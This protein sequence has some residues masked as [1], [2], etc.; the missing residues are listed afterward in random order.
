MGKTYIRE[1]VA[2]IYI[3]SQCGVIKKVYETEFDVEMYLGL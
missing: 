1:K 2:D 3:Y